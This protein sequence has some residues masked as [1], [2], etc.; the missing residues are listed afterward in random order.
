MPEIRE[1]NEDQLDRWVAAMRTGLDETDTAEG[2]LDWKRQARETAWLVATEAGVDVGA[3]IGIGGWH[4]PEGVARGE[5]R[6]AVAARGRGV[7]SALLAA[8][9]AWARGLRYAELMGPV[10]ELDAESLAWTQKRGFAEVGRNS[11]LALDLL[12]RSHQLGVPKPARPGGELGEQ[13]RADP[14]TARGGGDS[15]LAAG[16]AL[17]RVPAADPDRGADVD[18]VLG[19]E[20]PHRLARLA[21]PVEVALGGVGLVEPGAHRRDPAVELVLVDLADLGHG[22]QRTRALPVRLRAGIGSS[23]RAVSANPR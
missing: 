7:G 18:A 11:I 3:A 13:G 10:K 16:D 22:R 5:V 6:V 8:L 12:D 1:L 20:E 4:A 9:S 17:G 15:D 19:R 21:L 23:H 2:Y 14:A